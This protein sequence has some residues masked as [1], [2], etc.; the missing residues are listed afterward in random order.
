MLRRTLILV[1]ILLAAPVLRAQETTATVTGTVADETGAVLPGVRVSAT[2]A[3]TGVAKEVVTT[4]AGRYTLPFVPI[5]EYEV[6]FRLPG[7]QPHVVRRVTLHVNDRVTIDATLRVSGPQASLE[8]EGDVV[9]LQA[10]P[11]VQTLIRPLQ[12]QE[13]PLNNRNF[14]QLATLVPGVSSALPDEV[15]IGLTQTISLSLAGGRRNA[16]NWFVDGAS[17]VDAGSNITLLS[18]PTLESIQEFRI[19]TSSYAAEWP[20]SGGG[21]VNV[22]TRS[23]SNVFRASAYEFLRNDAL[24]ANSFFRKQS[25]DPAVRDSP[26]Q[27]DYHNFGYTLGG[28]LRRDRLFFFWSQEW[29]DI[30]RAPSDRAATVPDPAWLVDPA[31]PNY[32]PEALRDPNAVRLLSAY[33]APNT[34]SNQYRS[35][36]PNTQNT[37]QEVLRL[38]WMPSSRQRLMLR[39]T[40]DLSKTTEAGGLFF[41]TP[42]PDIA[43]TLTRV[44]GTVLVAQL[45]TTLGGRTLNELS[46]Q[47]S[48]NAIGSSFAPGVRNTRTAFGLQ[49][50]ELS[51]ENRG[52]LVPQVAITGLSAIGANQLFDNSYRNATLA[53]S[54]SHQRGNHTLKAGFLLALEQKNEIS[55]AATQGS[56]SFGAGGGRTAFQNFLTGNI[57]GLCGAACTYTE[58]ESEIASQLRWQRYEA[59]VQDSWRVRPGLTLDVGLRYAVYPGV[60]DANELLSNFVPALFDPARAP[61]WTGPDATTL[62]AGSGDFANGIVVAG[63]NSPHGRSVQPTEWNKLQPRAGFAWDLGRRGQTVV[64]GGFGIY[65]DQPL[66][67]ILLQ[68][69]ATNPP[70]AS[71]PSIVDPLLSNPGAGTSRSALPPASLS[72]T[73]E[74]F[75]L[76]R[77]LQYNLGVQ[78]QLFRRLVL[79]V[80]YL[81]STGSRLIQPV[82]VNAPTPAEVVA[83]GGNLNLARPYQG[84]ASIVTRQTS[85]RS[86]YDALATALRYDAG[87]A[88]LSIAYT[89]SRSRATATNDRD[90]VDLP[91]DRT[92]L[93]AEYALARNDRTHVFTASWV[94]ELP[95]ARGTPSRALK[96]VLS[97]WQVAGIASFWSGPPISRVVTGNTNGGR[98]GSRLDAIG[99]AFAERARERPRLR[100]LVRPGRLRA[101]RRRSARLDRARD[102]PAAGRG[103]VG[104][105]D[106]EELR[107]AGSPAAAAAGR[108]HQRL[109]PHTARP[110]D[111]PERLHGERRQLCGRRLQLRPHHRHAQPARDPA[112]AAAQLQLISRGRRCAGRAA[113]R[114]RSARD[115]RRA[116]RRTLRPRRPAP[117]AGSCWQ[118]ARGRSAARPRPGP[119]GRSAGHGSSRNSRERS[120]PRGAS[121]A[122]G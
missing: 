19:L 72:A 14:V 84:Y 4:E 28:P 92:D 74:D 93:D 37:R 86:R 108:L 48:S 113:V 105:D 6:A 114:A 42:L 51:A 95:L 44:P 118:P 10:S 65:Y 121:R 35:P 100:L 60:V 38:D 8:V 22:V 34:G 120:A 11:F 75:S 58:P 59:F 109:Q 30:D 66:V 46:L 53:D 91:Q 20:R 16:V 54:F 122:S 70:F 112:R 77:M 119:A 101:A 47:Y 24:D 1:A 41:N 63:R 96:T 78:R 102:L 13:L 117:C 36:A 62:V 80:G 17:N 61:R 97:G 83:A 25:S 87:S 33:P 90:A 5:G 107:A 49:V 103:A 56:F 64:R 73:S 98:R 111:D 110:G 23:G 12:V 99:A 79:D 68:N 21:V 67:G 116:G 85:A 9:P 50:P 52:G 2:S 81:G 26:P 115:R 69:A 40:R 31:S 88:T 106:R 27:L 3:E 18:T 82:D 29:R 104:P 45:T 57:D 71:S 43:T 7:F 89:L 55:T 94:W 15:G 76:P 32:V 39:Y